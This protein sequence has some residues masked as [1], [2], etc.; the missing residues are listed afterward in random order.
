MSRGAHIQ[1]A[2]SPAAVGA[3]PAE[4]GRQ[5]LKFVRLLATAQC[6]AAEAAAAAGRRTG[7]LSLVVLEATKP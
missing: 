5:G 4:R 2:A 1:F 7:A 6:G 3:S